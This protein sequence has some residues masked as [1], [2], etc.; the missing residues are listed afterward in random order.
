MC[1]SWASINA[2]S[3]C[4]LANTPKRKRCPFYLK[5]FHFKLAIMF[6]LVIWNQLGLKL[7]YSGREEAR[8]SLSPHAPR[9]Q[10]GSLILLHSIHSY[11]LFNSWVILGSGEDE[12]I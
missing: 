3:T 2:K 10:T 8:Y 6:N 11:F 9:P 5:S 7:C 1:V 12:Q 4:W